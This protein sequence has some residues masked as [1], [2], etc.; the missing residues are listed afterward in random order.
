MLTIAENI[1]DEVY[2][3]ADTIVS[4]K[5]TKKLSWTNVYKEI[6]I[7]LGFEDKIKDNIFLINVIRRITIL[8]YDIL[9]YP[10]RLERFR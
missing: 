2:L 9:S 1:K 3:V 4:Y 10:F 7:E 5:N 8:G 6:L